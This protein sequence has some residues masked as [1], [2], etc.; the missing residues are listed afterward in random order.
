MPIHTASKLTSQLWHIFG[1]LLEEKL[2]STCPFCCVHL[3]HVGTATRMSTLLLCEA[4]FCYWPRQLDVL[5]GS[6]EKG[7]IK[8]ST[9]QELSG[10]IAILENTGKCRNF[11][12]NRHL[13]GK[14][15]FSFSE[16]RGKTSVLRHMH[17]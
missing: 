10:N 5:I 11:H 13:L 16:K 9:N 12:G 17:G 14:F 15:S 4:H 2:T 3:P 1:Y 7:V 8:V 6:W